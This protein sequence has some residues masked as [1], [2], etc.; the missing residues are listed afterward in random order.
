ML[1]KP[2]HDLPQ[3]PELNY[4]KEQGAVEAREGLLSLV[5]G[6]RGVTS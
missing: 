2:S 1:L 5:D 3:G 4:S 6:A